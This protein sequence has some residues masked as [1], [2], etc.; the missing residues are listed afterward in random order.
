MKMI[1]E[2]KQIQDT[3][4]QIDRLEHKNVDKALAK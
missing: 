2:R 3:I 4:K 1:N